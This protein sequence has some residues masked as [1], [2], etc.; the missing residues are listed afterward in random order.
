MQSCI[1]SLATQLIIAGAQTHK[2]RALAREQ[3]Y[4]PSCLSLVLNDIDSGS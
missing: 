2:E 3:I 1:E 4:A